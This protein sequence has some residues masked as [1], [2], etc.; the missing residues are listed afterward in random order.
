MLLF[1]SPEQIKA[2]TEVLYK[3]RT[4]QQVKLRFGVRNRL[5]LVAAIRNGKSEDYA[6]H[7]RFQWVKNTK[8]AAIQL[9]NEKSK[10][11]ALTRPHDAISL[12]DMID[13]AEAL[14][15]TLRAIEKS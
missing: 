15:N 9:M 5:E 13:C 1:M 14:L 6:S 10:E 4:D 7:P 3:A 8:D 12:Q 2:V 11:Y